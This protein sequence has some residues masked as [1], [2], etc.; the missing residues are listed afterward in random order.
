MC[1]SAGWD[2][3][4]VV[5]VGAVWLCRWGCVGPIGSGPEVILRGEKVVNWLGRLACGGW[6]GSTVGQSLPAL[7]ERLPL[8]AIC[9]H[10]SSERASTAYAAM[11]PWHLW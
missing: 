10:V 9:H 3:W 5:V 11:L 8:S 4:L 7:P 2:G 1:F 6:C